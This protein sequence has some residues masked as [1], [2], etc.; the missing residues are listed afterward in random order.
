MCWKLFWITIEL[1]D[2]IEN[3]RPKSDWDRLFLPQIGEISNIEES[4]DNLR[5]LRNR[6]AHCIFFRKEHYEECLKLLDG[7]NKQLNKAL[8]I[9]MNIDFNNLHFM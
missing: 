9:V 3:I 1:V 4:I 2:Y 5:K 6:V 8:K 7:L